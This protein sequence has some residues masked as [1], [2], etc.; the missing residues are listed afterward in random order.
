ML[1]REAFLKAMH[2]IL[3]R[4]KRLMKIS[5]DLRALGVELLDDPLEEI[6][7]DTLD[8][9]LETNL[10]EHHG[11]VSWWMYDCGISRAKGEPAIATIKGKE[12]KIITPENVYDYALALVDNAKT[13][14]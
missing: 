14:T 4:E 5:P 13:T 10:P 9:A 1:S 3:E 12:F 8:S 6:L 7:I 11:V 2:V